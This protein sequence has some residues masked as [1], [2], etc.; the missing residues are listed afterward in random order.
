MNRYQKSYTT[1]STTRYGMDF[2]NFQI[3]QKSVVPH[4]NQN[5]S[6]SSYSGVTNHFKH[7]TDLEKRFLLEKVK[8]GDDY[9]YLSEQLGRTPKAIYCQ[10]RTI[11]YNMMTRDNVKIEDAVAKT[12]LAAEEIEAW[13][14]VR[15]FETVHE[16]EVNSSTRSSAVFHSSSN[17]VNPPHLYL[18]T[19]AED[20]N[21]NEKN[22]VLKEMHRPADLPEVIGGRDDTHT[23]HSTHKKEVN[24]SNP[25]LMEMTKQ[26]ATTASAI[27]AAA[28]MQPM[29]VNIVGLLS[30][31]VEDQTNPSSSPR[32]SHH[33]SHHSKTTQSP[34][35]RIH[36]DN[37]RRYDR[38]NTETT[39]KSR[40][41]SRSR[42]SRR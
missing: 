15:K 17:P 33:S 24:S 12:K 42:S 14:S 4:F 18:D 16:K 22:R 32:Q 38:D 7:W 1:T 30:R 31:M 11:A 13:V 37:L 35:S 27:K 6:H 10:L 8:F 5:S 29:L 21:K 40:D 26:L 2:D 28:D 19:T 20:E 34:L 39:N 23:T 41:R 3:N 9:A 25:L 36:P